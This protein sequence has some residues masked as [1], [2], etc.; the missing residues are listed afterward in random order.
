MNLFVLLT[1]GDSVV[2]YT[3][4]FMVAAAGS[5]PIFPTCSFAKSGALYM[6]Y[7]A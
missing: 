3:P 5:V 1:S 4:A 2:G 6:L 7:S